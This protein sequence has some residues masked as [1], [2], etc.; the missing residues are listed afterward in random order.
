[1]PRFVVQ[2][3]FRSEEDWHFD[4]MLECKDALV[5]FSSGVPPDETSRLPCLV[6][7]L[8]NHRLAYLEHE[9]EVSGDRGWCKIHDRG[10]FEWVEPGDKHCPDAQVGQMACDYLDEI[11]VRLAGEKT[12]GVYRIAREPKSGA[13]YWRMRRESDG[14]TLTARRK[15]L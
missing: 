2:Q 13:D 14:V 6:R 12:R 4:L 9:G 15:S 11:A 3:H 7:Q 10:M 8:P 1:M 5:T